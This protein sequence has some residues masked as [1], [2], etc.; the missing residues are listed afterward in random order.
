MQSLCKCYANAMQTYANKT[1][2]NKNKTKSNKK[3]IKS[4][5]YNCLTVCLYACV[6]VGQSVKIYFLIF[7]SMK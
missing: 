2:L 5:K 4:K 6:K 3:E 7:S 1:K